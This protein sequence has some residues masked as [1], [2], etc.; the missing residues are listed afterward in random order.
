MALALPNHLRVG[1]AHM[2]KSSRHILSD[3]L[4]SLGEDEMGEMGEGRLL[5]WAAK[6]QS[7]KWGCA[8]FM[9]Q[10]KTHGNTD[11]SNKFTESSGGTGCPSCSSTLPGACA[12]GMLIS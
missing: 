11:A 1:T 10:P 12:R 5:L 3:L 9:V 2:T 7:L 8:S 4:K 6:L